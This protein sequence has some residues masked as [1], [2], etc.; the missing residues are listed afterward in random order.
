M[1]FTDVIANP[2]ANLAEWDAL[3]KGE[4]GLHVKY[5]KRLRQMFRMHKKKLE[6]VNQIRLDH[7]NHPGYYEKGY[8]DGG[9]SRVEAQAAVSDDTLA[10]N[11]KVK[12]LIAILKCLRAEHEI[13]DLLE[14]DGRYVVEPDETD[15]PDDTTL[16]PDTAV[17]TA[18][19][20]TITRSPIG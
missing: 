19:D 9:M 8:M 14:A 13:R 17:I 12:H 7:V 5:R 11:Q 16:E 6:K 20:G 15:I 3:L 1:A 10:L 18:I 2:P 4:Y